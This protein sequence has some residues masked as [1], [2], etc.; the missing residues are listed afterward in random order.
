[1]ILKKKC[2][3]DPL[4]L[5]AFRPYVF[6]IATSMHE[7]WMIR[8]FGIRKRKNQVFYNGIEDLGFLLNNTLSTSKLS[9]VDTVL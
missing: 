7:I 9:P 3:S 1:V 6:T 5:L 2:N 4:R 8:V